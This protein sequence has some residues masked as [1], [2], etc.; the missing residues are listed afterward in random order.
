MCQSRRRRRTGE[1]RDALQRSSGRRAQLFGSQRATPGLRRV[2]N[3]TTSVR[4]GH[5]A[6]HDS[7]ILGD[8]LKLATDVVLVSEPELAAMRESGG[9]GL[10]NEP[11]RSAVR[12]SECGGI[13]EER[14]RIEDLKNGRNRSPQRST[15]SE[16]QRPE[17][18]RQLTCTR[19]V[20][21]LKDSPVRGGRERE[22]LV[23]NIGREIAEK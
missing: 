4:S 15:A 5:N 3:Q 20:N 10:R 6:D 7:Q 22:R 9:E 16:R 13:I 2:T 17:R 23:G 8:V 14:P 19:R 12:R 1:G 21:A 18:L 11:T